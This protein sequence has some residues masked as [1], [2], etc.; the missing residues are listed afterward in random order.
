VK[1]R[2]ESAP[3]IVYSTEPGW[4]PNYEVRTGPAALGM[5][6]TEGALAVVSLEKRVKGKAVTLVSGLVAHEDDLLALAKK[7]KARCSAG[8]TVQEGV[9]EVQGDHR[10]TVSKVLQDMGYAVKRKG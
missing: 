2:K 8:G 5:P 10:D 6:A 1:P 3:K 4:K 7:L 9:V